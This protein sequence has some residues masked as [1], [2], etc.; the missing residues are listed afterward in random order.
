MLKK[1]IGYGFSYF[2][3]IS[4]SLLFICS[5]AFIV[6]NIYEFRI[7]N[8]SFLLPSIL[9]FFFIF[10][11]F[12][13]CKFPFGFRSLMIYGEAYAKNTKFEDYKKKIDY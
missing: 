13:D 1:F 5:Y 6:G 7:G 4:F 3:F 9:G 10:Y 2:I 8:N 12:F 11:S